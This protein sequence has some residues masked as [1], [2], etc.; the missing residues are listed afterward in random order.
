[1]TP[2]PPF[3]SIWPPSAGPRPTRCAR[4]ATDLAELRARSCA[5]AASPA[6]RASTRARLRAYPRAAC[7]RRGLARTASI[8]RKLA[9]VR[10]CLRFLARRGVGRVQNP[11]RHRSAEPRLP[12][13]GCRRSCRRTSPRTCWIGPPRRPPPGA[14]TARCSSCSTRA[15]CACRSAAGLDLRDVDRERGNVRVLGKGD[16]ERV[17]PVGEAALAALDALPRR[18]AAAPRRSA[19]REPPRRPAHRARRAPHR[20]SARPGRGN[21]RARAPARAA[22]QLRDPPARHGRRPAGDPGAA[23]PRAP[24]DDAALHPREPRALDGGLRR[25]PSP[26]ARAQPR[27]ERRSARPRTAAPA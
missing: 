10:S 2:S 7:T 4:Y 17:V 24:V 3:S 19:V 5:T 6:P 9:A 8:S 1:M 14:A 20:A 16:K 11:A 27:S 15:G 22:P 25:R 26:R 23:R 21:R 13:A 18:R 12:R